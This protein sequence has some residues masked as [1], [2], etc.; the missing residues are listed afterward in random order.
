MTQVYQAVA[1]VEADISAVQAQ[2][3]DNSDLIALGISGHINSCWTQA[4]MAKQ[5]ITERL[6]Q[7]E[8]QRRGEYDPDKAIDIAETGGSDIFMMLTDVKCAAA[9]S[10]IQDVMLQ[11]PRPFDLVP[12]QEPQ[13][14]PEVRLSIIDL[15]RTE[16]EDYVLA[17]Q[18]LHPE[19]FRKRMNEVHD[20][21]SMRVKEEAKATAE[22]MAQVIQD[23]LDTGKFKP[24]MQDFIDDF[25]T[26]PTAILKGPSV[27]RKKQLQ[28]GPNFTPVV[29]NDMVRE[30]SRV[31]PYDIF[32]SA[33]SMGVDDGFLIQRHRL[34]AKTLES[35]KGVPGY[36]DDDIDQVIIRY[37]KAGYRYNE[38]GD[39]QRDDL[40][41]KTNSQMHNDH[42]IEA[43]EFWGPVMGDSVGHERRRAE[44]GLRNQCLASCQLHHQ[45][46]DQ[47]RSTG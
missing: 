42:L 28:W 27:R 37:G 33:N 39:Q 38:F 35:L 5:D 43:L 12:A 30:V 15:V 25:V 3:V 22:R 19:T 23:Q 26:F 40:E 16:A 34:S 44:Q 31:S 13:I 10:W 21:I 11:A 24:A 2:G 20:M 18:E 47:P 45:G 7:C 6:L 46:C 41:G 29:V 9:K 8:R 1:P 4:K 36:S 32:P 17:G 14:P